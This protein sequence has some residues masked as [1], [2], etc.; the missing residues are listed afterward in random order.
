MGTSQVTRFSEGRP[1][2]IVFH[3]EVDRCGFR[4]TAS[5]KRNLCATF[6]RMVGHSYK[7]EL[8]QSRIARAAHGV[9][10]DYPCVVAKYL[11][12]SRVVLGK[13]GLLPVEAKP[14]SKAVTGRFGPTGLTDFVVTSK[15]SFTRQLDGRTQISGRWPTR[16]DLSSD[17]RQHHPGRRP[18]TEPVSKL[19]FRR[20]VDRVRGAGLIQRI[21]AARLYV[22]P[23]VKA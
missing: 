7:A 21:E 5:A 16:E 13:Q 1:S 11:P 6:V 20:Q 2:T 8:H 15:T 12:I 14:T 22:T 9:R 23:V 18:S 17:M 3:R 19:K 4:P 10:A